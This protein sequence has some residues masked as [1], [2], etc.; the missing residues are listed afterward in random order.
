M[1]IM[2]CALI[3]NVKAVNAG[4]TPKKCT[5]TE[6]CCK[7]CKAPKCMELAKQWSNMS[8]ES[9]AGEE[10]RKVKEE[11]M[12]ICETEKC[13][14]ASGKVACAEKEGKACCKKK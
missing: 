6:L 5:S 2:L 7:S 4:E 1:A 11:C 10:G 3:I 9:R 12:R 14:S 13:C 8:A